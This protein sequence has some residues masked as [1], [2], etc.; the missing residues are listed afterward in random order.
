ML[1][2]RTQVRASR[3]PRLTPPWTPGL[4]DRGPVARTTSARKA[5]SASRAS[6]APACSTAANAPARVGQRAHFP[7]TAAILSARGM[8][9]AS[10]TGSIAR[11][12]GPEVDAR[13]AAVDQQRH[14]RDEGDRPEPEPEP[15]PESPRSAR[16]RRQ[17][18]RQRA[19]AA[20]RWAVRPR[21]GADEVRCRS[22]RRSSASSR[23][24]RSW[25]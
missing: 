21:C 8:G 11:V 7:S 12:H 9:A 17:R 19:A 13:R 18:D 23:R 24:S 20:S 1:A 25:G 6:A 5:L 15:E 3:M 16:A 14:S 10:G 4:T 2:R 22:P